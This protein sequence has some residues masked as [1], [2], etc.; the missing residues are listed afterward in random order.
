MDFSIEFGQ[1]DKV[2]ERAAKYERAAE[3]APQHIAKFA[4]EAGNLYLKNLKSSAPVDTGTLKGKLRIEMSGGGS[5]WR[6]KP[7]SDV[8]HL[9]FVINDTAPHQIV[10]VRAPSLTFFWKRYGRVVRLQSVS[11]PGTKANKFDEKAMQAT[12]PELS[13]R[14]QSLRKVLF[15]S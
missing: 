11:H 13:K 12:L 14:A 2:R 6:I 3:E 5:D 9:K 15:P 4:V 1:L 10:P 8:P 7:I